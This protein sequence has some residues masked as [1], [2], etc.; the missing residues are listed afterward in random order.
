MS[1][2]RFENPENGAFYDW[3]VNHKDEE[4]LGKRRNMERGA[5][6]SGTGLIRQ[7]TDQTPM[8]MRFSGTIFHQSQ[9][10]EMWEWY[11]LCENQTIYFHDFSGDSYEVTITAFEPT[12]H[13]TVRNPRDFANAPYWFWR[14]T[15]EMEVLT[16][17]DGSMAEAGVTP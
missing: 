13:H 11:E 12:R 2:N 14:Y 1:R 16:F 3:L 15:I 17:I 7:Q 10:D 8:V 4:S 9:Y 5:K 6:T